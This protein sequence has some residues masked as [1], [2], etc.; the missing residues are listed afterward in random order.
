L[1]AAGCYPPQM[2]RRLPWL[3]PVLVTA[4]PALADTPVLHEYVP[5]IAGQEDPALVA[6]PGE[7]PTAFL[8]EGEVL[9]APE[10]GALR[11]D[12]AR[13]TATTSL[14]EG[15]SALDGGYSYRPDRVT[16]LEGT[17]GYFSVFNPAITPFK[18]VLALDRVVEGEDGTP[19]LVVSDPAARPVP[20]VGAEGGAERGAGRD[21]FWGSV[22]VDFSE[23]ARVPLPSVAPDARIL[24]L[25]TEPE[26]LVRIERDG[27]DNFYV[28][29][30]SPG[31]G[32][33]RLTFL[34]DAPQAYFNTP[35]P[36]VASDAMEDEVPPVPAPIR[37][38]AL[39]FA[40][41]LGLRP[42]DDLPRV[43]E[44]L[45]AHFRSFEEGD[46]PL[47]DTGDIYLDLAHGMR[48]VCRHRAYA[49]VI[50]LMA[51]GVPARFVRNEAHA[52]AEVRLPSVGFMRVDLGGAAVGLRSHGSDGRPWYR[53]RS[54]DPL[55]QPPAYRSNYSHLVEE[56]GPASSGGSGPDARPVDGAGAQAVAVGGARRVPLRIVVDRRHHDAFRGRSIEVGGRI[57]DPLGHGVPTMRVEILLS[58]DRELLLGVAITGAGGRFDATVGI[59][60][61]IPVG[62]YRLLVRSPG[63]EGHEP[64]VAP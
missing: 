38:H 62:D 12:E 42:G 15:G 33:V 39:S 60:P 64:A 23:G 56:E 44:V 25:R 24:T 48:G 21:R 59:P 54:P 50:T 57:T 30:R 40:A 26:T 35:I 28:V 46:R 11:P 20:I 55:P 49:Y 34:T 3:L 32:P 52:W 41:E 9:R 8:Y 22:V 4:A 61:D 18:R 31:R 7:A 1:G 29:S 27:A 19:I 43:L 2:A 5:D 17:L 16:A 36:E 47:D 10:G 14:F 58:G 53:P 37:R 63:D 13:L 6:A 51:L 45:T